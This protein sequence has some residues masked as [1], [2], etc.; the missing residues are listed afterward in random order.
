MRV[1]NEEPETVSRM[2]S[3]ANRVL[4]PGGQLI[5]GAACYP[6]WINVAVDWFFVEEKNRMD[7]RR[8]E[9]LVVEQK[10]ESP[11]WQRATLGAGVMIAWKHKEDLRKKLTDD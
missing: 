1:G 7:S 5:L 2:L 3:E 9:K 4:K 10:L 8:L 11:S 6:A